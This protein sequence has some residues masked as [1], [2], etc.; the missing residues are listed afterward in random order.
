[1]IIDNYWANFSDFGPRVY[2]GIS[3][4]LFNLECFGLLTNF[5]ALF[6]LSR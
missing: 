2:I 1:M 6:Y 4:M 5:L 3:L